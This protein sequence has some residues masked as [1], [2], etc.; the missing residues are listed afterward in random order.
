M[1][2]LEYEL[3]SYDSAVH[4][5]NHY[6]TRTPLNQRSRRYPAK[7]IT[8]ADYTDDITILANAPAQAETQLH[9]LERAAAGI[10]LHVNAHQT[11]YMCFNQTGD[12]CALNG[13]SPETRRQVHLPR[14]QCLIDRDRH[15]HATNKGMDSS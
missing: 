2:R 13:R 12:I 1:A 5:F 15:R 4:R 7:I 8:D 6:T 9:S 3:A 14:K 11:E 10:G